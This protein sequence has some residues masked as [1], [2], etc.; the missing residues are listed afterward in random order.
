MEEIVRPWSTGG[1][2]VLDTAVS[3]LAIL[4][5]DITPALKA[6]CSLYTHEGTCGISAGH[7]ELN[8]KQI[9]P[10]ICVFHNL[11]PWRD[12][13]GRFMTYNPGFERMV[14]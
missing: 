6:E 12:P 4:L 10:S 11:M 1:R 5:A 7:A 8:G 2:R 9:D 3:T 13:I 14:R